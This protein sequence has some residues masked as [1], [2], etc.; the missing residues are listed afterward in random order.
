MQG[1]RRRGN[2]EVTASLSGVRLKLDRAKQHLDTL[3][4]D[5]RQF[6]EADD[7][8]I[9]SSH[10]VLDDSWSAV[11]KAKPLPDHWGILVGDVF[12]NLRCT[13]DH[14]V[15]QLVILANGTV[16]DMHQF[17]IFDKTDD[18]QRRVVQPPRKGRRGLLD[19]IDPQHVGLIES[20]Q[21][22]NPT[23]GLPSLATI[24]RFSNADKHRLIHVARTN[25]TARPRLIAATSIPTKVTEVVYKDPG[26]PLEDGTEIAR[27]RGELVFPVHPLTG[28]RQLPPDAEVTVNIHLNTT[29]VFGEQGQ[30]DTRIRDFRTCLADAQS[31]VDRF[32]TA[33]R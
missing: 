2:Q 22:Y 20:L 33:F 8:T 10:N 23:T 12:H 7:H 1:P 18:W 9:I 28:Q 16:H 32:A 13:L 3:A 29:T 6:M 14:L 30:E 21:Q 17:P 25:L 15:A 27:Y 4:A 5:V 11:F 26:T 31:I 24:R 19:F